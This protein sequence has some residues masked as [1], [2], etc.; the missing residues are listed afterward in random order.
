MGSLLTKPAYKRRMQFSVSFKGRILL[1]NPNQW[2]LTDFSVVPFRL[3]FMLFS[4]E[5]HMKVHKNQ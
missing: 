5:N 3:N 2:Y 1:A 4:E